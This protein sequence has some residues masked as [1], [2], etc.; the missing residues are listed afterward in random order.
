[1]SLPWN[2][3]GQI[4]IKIGNLHI[5]HALPEKLFGIN[6]YYKL[7]FAMHIE[8]IFQTSARKI[9][10]LARLAPYMT[11][12][13]KRIL[14]NAFFRSQF[15]YCPLIWMCCNH[16]LSNKINW[17]YDRCLPIQIWRTSRKRWFCLYW[18]FCL[19]AMTFMFLF[20]NTLMQAE[21]WIL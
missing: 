13:K 3:K 8:G 12:L 5:K 11:P 6:F 19:Y 2:I 1:M 7:N 10:A 20:L 18:W 9:N 16:S 21:L 4:T 15:N 14:M 17:L